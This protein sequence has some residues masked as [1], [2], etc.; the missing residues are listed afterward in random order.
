[1][2]A[3]DGE[4]DLARAALDAARK[5]RVARGG[6]PSLRRAAAEDRRRRGPTGAGPDPNDP[7][8]VGQLLDRLVRDRGW[9]RAVA[10]A[11]VVGRWEHLVGADIAAHCQPESLRDGVLVL[12]AESTA[13]AT[14]LRL[15]SGRI[16]A[17]V[18]RE[19]GTGIVTRV[20][21]HGPTAPNWRKGPRHISG[22]GPRDT[23]G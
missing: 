11:T 15:L 23:Y 4:R 19:V 7:Q 5:S 16:A 13:W 20:R 17:A 21:V 6:D 1:M 8:P 18:T 12:A 9:E 14:Q 22:R 3:E 10:E 2:S